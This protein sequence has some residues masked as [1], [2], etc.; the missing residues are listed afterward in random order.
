VEDTLEEY[1]V[2]PCTCN[3]C[4]A[5]CKPND[6]DAFP[7]FFDG[8]NW[9]VVGLVYLGLAVLSVIIFFVKKRWQT[10]EDD[11]A[12]MG[13]DDQGKGIL[14]SVDSSH[15]E[16]KEKLIN[17]STSNVESDAFGKING[18]SMNVSSDVH[19]NNQNF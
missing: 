15:T 9:L 14:D 12:S 2:A 16:G 1:E 8:F 10:E 5:A 18:S 6:I 4:E 11:E 17:N 19:S 3:Y 13:D 7:A